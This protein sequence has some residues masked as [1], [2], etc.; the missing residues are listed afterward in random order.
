MA[1]RHK[2][3]HKNHLGQTRNSPQARQLRSSQNSLQCLTTPKYSTAQTPV[4]LATRASTATRLARS[5]A[6]V[7]D[8]KASG[9]KVAAVDNGQPTTA[10]TFLV[11]AGSRYEPSPG[12]AHAL[13][14]FAFKSTAKRSTLGTV[15]ESEL[16]GGV[17]SASL[18]R[19]YLAFT[20]EFL[21]GDE[22]FFTSLLTSI[23][24]TPKFLPHEYLEYVVPV[25]RD[26]AT[27]ASKTPSTVAIEAAHAL[28]FRTGLG[29]SLF[30][31]PHSHV[32]LDSVKSFS[33]EAF[34]SGNI[35]VVGTGIDSASLAT[36]VDNA[37][38]EASLPTANAPLSS[39]P[40]KYFGGSTRIDSHEGPETV[41]I[42]FGT[43]TPSPALSVLSAHI[44]PSQSL[45]YPTVSRPSTTITPVHLPYS[46]AVLTGALVQGPDVKS[47]K[48]AAKAVVDKLK[49]PLSAEELKI[50]VARAKFG[51]AA[52]VEGRE[53]LMDALGS[54]VFSNGNASIESTLAA[55]DTVDA[56]TVS[57]VIAGLTKTT[58]TFVVVGNVQTLP[59]ADELG[60]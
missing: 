48:E 52:T 35:A 32:S 25:V 49:T 44:A 11:K 59:Y 2:F 26:E 21:R 39:S 4:M 18:S 15:R 29:A 50:A 46:D 43:T 38:A 7:V 3:T 9:I 53:G 56:A 14:N 17:L 23:L 22:S 40:S 13:K 12:V 41:F 19:E 57:K 42:G 1:H 36:L 45:K 28:A 24:T 58:P 33:K 16:Y 6:T 10:L 20:S 5:F 31:G 37:L 60:L 47:V 51:A 8:T 34:T 30:A 54:K 27:V 55:F